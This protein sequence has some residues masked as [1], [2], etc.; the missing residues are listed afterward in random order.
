LALLAALAWAG[1][2]YASDQP[3]YAPPPA[4]VKPIPIPVVPAPNDGSATQLLLM[5]DQS[6]LGPDGDQVFAQ[7]VIRVLTPQGLGAIGNIAQT[8]NPDTED[9]TIHHLNIIRGGQVIDALAGGKKFIILRRENNL[10]LAM[11]DGTLTA[12]IQPEGLQV[13]DM[14]DVAA[15]VTRHD[16][17]LRG[18]SAMVDA[19]R[20]QGVAGRIYI[21]ELWPA[22]KTIRWRITD[23]MTAPV[24]AKTADGS[25]LVI[26]MS[27][28]QTP[29]PPIGA[30][31]RFA[32]LGTL[33][34]SQFDDWA[35]V[36]SLMAPLYAKATSLRA[37]SPLE[38][39][40]ARIAAASPD[41]KARAAAALA[42]VQN[43][44][45]YVFLGMNDGG[46]VPAD[47]DETWAR[48]FGD[49]KGKS[50]LL[51]AIL[52][53]LGVDARP[54]MVSTVAGDGMDQRL[55]SPSWFDH[56]IVRAQIAGK[57][58]WLDGT[59]SGD[60]DLDALTPPTFEWALPIQSAGATLTQL[61]RKPLARPED[62]G[63]LTIDASAGYDA[64]APTRIEHDYRGE[65]AIGMHLAM[66]STP[67]ADLE[68]GLRESWSKIYPWFTI[69]QVGA[70]YDATSG[71]VR[72]WA[73]GTSK[74]EWSATPSGGRFYHVPYTA[75]GQNVSFKRE[76]GFHQDAPY[77]VAFPY[78]VRMVK[79]LTLP[80]GGR[81]ALVGADIDQT[82]AG[83][84]LKRKSRIEDGVLTIESSTRSVAPEFPAAEAE[85]AGTTMRDLAMKDVSV[86]QS[87][88]LAA[89]PDVPAASDLTRAAA[90]RGDA[91]A[92]YALAI[93]YANGAGVPYD[94]PQSQVWLRKAA[95]AGYVKAE[96]GLG[97]L[98]EH[99]YGVAQDDAQ[100]MVWFAKAADQGDPT[101]EVSLGILYTKAA[102]GLADPVKATALFRKAADQGD[103]YGE[104]N[105][106]VSYDLGRG[107]PR[108]RA[109]SMIWLVKAADKG[110]AVAQHNLGLA[111]LRGAGTP[112][113][114]ALAASWFRKAA[115]QGDAGAQVDLGW[116][117]ET[118]RGVTQDYAEALAWYRKSAEQGNAAGQDRL[119]LMYD[120][121]RGVPQDFAQ[122]LAWYRKAAD[123]GDANAEND[124]AVM[125][126]GGRGVPKDYG[127]AIA[128]LKKA[129][130]TDNVVA[131]VNL[132][133]MYREE[134]AVRDY[135][136]A[137][138]WFVKAAAHRNALAEYGLGEMARMGQGGAIDL[139][140]AR[141][142][143]QRAA[144]DGSLDAPLVLSRMNIAAPAVGDS[145]RQAF[146]SGLAA[147]SGLAALAQGG[148]A[149]AERELGEKYASGRGA[150]QDFALAAQWFR[151]AADQGDA[152]AQNRL[153][154]MY[155]AGRGVGR[156]DTQAAAW[157]RKA[158]DQG[159]AGAQQNLAI[160]Y[161]LGQ[162]APRDLTEAAGWFRKAADQ[163]LALSQDNLGAFYELG[164]GVPQDFAQA[165]AW[166]RKAAD[167]GYAMAQWNLG[168]LYFRGHGALQD[169]AQAAAWF[170]KAADQGLAGA[171]VSL[172]YCYQTGRGTPKDP[173]M[174]VAFYRK[175][176]DQGDTNGTT[177]LATAYLRGDGVARDPAQAAALFA[178]A[179]NQGGVMAQYALG[180]LLARGDAGVAADKAQ[181]LTWLRRA[182][183]GGDTDA[184]SEIE[185]L[186][187]A[188]KLAADA[189]GP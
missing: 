97:Q 90:E 123:Q 164:S 116:A 62:D 133:R 92:Q 31:G 78:F 176:A 135:D 121:A 65:T 178:K 1:A 155:R 21:R 103:V 140:K 129:A 89:A 33:A 146:Q 22:S 51:V 174:A 118:G 163:G 167:Q 153:G 38:A 145:A 13:G 154:E 63:R 168:K 113:D 16:P 114:P 86:M 48:R 119:G 159:L 49:C 162:G 45:R 35:A 160:L 34:L 182:A 100:A 26:D 70:D 72:Q 158:A 101:A 67:R 7:S 184:A 12:T 126:S 20:H 39:E 150:T 106:A 181:A 79:Q 124:L 9:L 134:V 91:A 130:A 166:H 183:S 6:Y 179:A 98:Y 189:G 120:K 29:H 175:A 42:L 85:T 14:V 102:P 58:Y 171:Q 107:V 19:L 99:G 173:A 122:A 161:Y 77:A 43:E 136:Q 141:Y 138:V 27:G 110:N 57:V 2:A 73:E 56:V 15:T 169:D 143:L 74:I 50:A 88:A 68:R 117:Y 10:E 147:S 165:A 96:L 148:D 149:V 109:Q 32:E 37:G 60:R 18:K 185:R 177:N 142:W 127:Q 11:L 111:Y 24:T 152:L 23:G 46:L 4:W 157:F 76:P 41:P 137:N 186:Q 156:D 75:L 52:T 47:A 17:A 81:F 40:I 66:T 115:D 125:Y 55:P 139:V 64:P 112:R 187:G 94:Q 53:R 30:P 28:V 144:D 105:L 84:E 104:L 87:A 108:D 82:V 25:E 151:K 180:R 93:A 36:S 44:T 5:N 80:K 131:E 59:R 132:G 188:D 8:W 3:Q 83:L 69:A 54:A 61:E 172:G 128:W 71:V 170:R 95:E